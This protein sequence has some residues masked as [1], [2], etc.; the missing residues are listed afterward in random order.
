MHA[1]RE[2]QLS[3]KKV[4][5]LHTFLQNLHSEDNND[6][7]LV[8]PFSNTMTQENKEVS[9]AHTVIAHIELLLLKR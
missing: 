7:K 3:L 1:M 4:N 5:N 2:M 9:V 8:A 6:D